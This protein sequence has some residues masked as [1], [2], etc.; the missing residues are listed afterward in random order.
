MHS[1]SF[2]DFLESL[3]RP[4]GSFVVWPLLLCPNLI[5]NIFLCSLPYHH[6]S[7]L[8]SGWGWGRHSLKMPSSF[9]PQGL[10]I[11]CSFCL[12]HFLLSTHQLVHFFSAFACWVHLPKT[13]LNPALTHL[14]PATTSKFILLLSRTPG[15]TTHSSAWLR[16]ASPIRLSTP[17]GQGHLCLSHPQQ[18]PAQHLASICPSPPCNLSL[19]ST[20]FQPKLFKHIQVSSYL[21]ISNRNKREKIPISPTF[22]LSASP[23]LYIF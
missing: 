3:M 6:T 8:F 21:C 16:P 14:I 20:W 5:C 22:W 2:L 1:S 17:W 13:F 4:T 18:H 7:L 15:V 11:Y 9:L 12:E 10:H 19:S 23:P